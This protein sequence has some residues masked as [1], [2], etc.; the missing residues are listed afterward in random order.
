MKK[1]VRQ[2]PEEQRPR[3]ETT[4]APDKDLKQIIAAARRL[5]SFKVVDARAIED[6]LYDRQ[7][8]PK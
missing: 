5:Q 7:G 3:S 8:M 6:V 4:K 2:V 1:E